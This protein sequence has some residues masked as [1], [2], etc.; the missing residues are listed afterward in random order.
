VRSLHVA[1]VLQMRGFLLFLVLAFPIVVASPAFWSL[2][3][4]EFSAAPV[5]YGQQDGTMQPALLGPKA[6]WPKWAEVPADADLRVRAW[7][8]P[9]SSAPE[10]GFGDLTV[11]AEPRATARAYAKR[12]IGEGWQ[13][14][15]A[16]FR[17]VLPEL[18]PKPLV[19]CIVRA[20]RGNGDPRVISVSF[21]LE[22]RIGGG[23]MHW[24][25]GAMPM[26]IGA[27]PGPC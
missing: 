26:P 3:A 25:M 4:M 12:L 7:F 6:P 10:T 16:I 27:T 20:A 1:R 5:G 11:K 9:G 15:T 24:S 2:V 22:P 13:V 21:E 14:E 23:R 19:W 8:G 17:S 18:P